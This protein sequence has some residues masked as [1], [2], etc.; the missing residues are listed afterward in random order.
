MP[1]SD[2]IADAL[3]CAAD[4]LW[5]RGR[6]KGTPVDADG[7]CVRGAIC[8]AVGVTPHTF[9]WDAE[10][11]AVFAAYLASHPETL[12]PVE[13]LFHTAWI[14]RG[15]FPSWCWNDACND[16]ELVTD[17]LRRCAK[18]LREEAGAA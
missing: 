17:T 16:D 7:Y 12:T 14:E 8:E 10:A 4:L 6:V 5:L 1:T 3:D 2:E 13:R 11:R 9:P 18:K 15:S